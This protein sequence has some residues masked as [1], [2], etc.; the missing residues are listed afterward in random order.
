MLYLRIIALKC[1]VLFTLVTGTLHA[2]CADY[3]CDSSVVRGILDAAGWD[4]V[5]VEDIVNTQAGRI[6]YLDL[7][8]RNLDTLPASIGALTGLKELKLSENTLSG[9]PNELGSLT[10]LNTIEADN[11]NLQVFSS[12]LLALTNLS[13]LNFSHNNIIYLPSLI[14]ELDNLNTINLS[15]NNLDSI[16][17]GFEKLLQLQELNLSNNQLTALP[18]D[19]VQL[20]TITD[21]DI[22]NNLLDSLPADIIHLT[23]TSLDVRNNRLCNVPVP[24][25]A[26]LNQYSKNSAGLPIDWASTQQC[27]Q[28][29][30]AADNS[31]GKTYGLLFD[32]L[33]RYLRFLPGSPAIFSIIIQDLHGKVVYNEHN[34]PLETVIDLSHAS[35]GLYVVVLNGEWSQKFILN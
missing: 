8:S 18:G 24:I 15:Y 25:I 22:S 21:M 13:I 10:L 5:Q 31:P 9:L 7:S 2:Q 29:P 32:P 19:I 33:H 4:L 14:F 6:T 11:N 23:V 26:W 34:T 35:S 12:P 16:P 1:I 3:A 28:A 27:G 20:H 30:I 17:P